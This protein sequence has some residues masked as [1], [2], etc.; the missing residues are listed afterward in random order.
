MLVAYTNNPSFL[1]G[2]DWDNHNMPSSREPIS[3]N[4]E[5]GLVMSCLSFQ[6]GKKHNRRIKLQAGLNINWRRSISKL[7]KAKMTEGMAHMVENLPRKGKTSSSN[8][9]TTSPPSPKTD[10]R[11]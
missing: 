6:L 4:K 1:G 3:T 10:V 7:T 9:S 11:H 2:G 8:P 5:L